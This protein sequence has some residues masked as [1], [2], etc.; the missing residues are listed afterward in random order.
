MKFVKVAINTIA[1]ELEA[2]MNKFLADAPESCKLKN[3]KFSSHY[4]TSEDIDTFTAILI[5]EYNDRFL[6]EDE[7]D[8]I[9]KF[10]KL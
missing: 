3:I 6:D 10:K 5:F 1:S 4:D 7:K 8:A 9:E 2:D